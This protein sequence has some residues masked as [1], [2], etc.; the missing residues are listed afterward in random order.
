MSKFVNWVKQNPGTAGG[1]GAVIHRYYRLS[2]M[3]F[4]F[5]EE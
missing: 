2:C 5:Q 1:G 4:P 3:V